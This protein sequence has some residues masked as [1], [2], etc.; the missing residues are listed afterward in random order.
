MDVQMPEMD[1]EEAT[2]QICSRWPKDER[3]RII[4]MT[5]HA[6]KGDRERYMEAGMDDY[7]TKPIRV[8]QLAK[9]LLRSTGSSSARRIGKGSD[10][11]A[12]GV[13]DVEVLGDETPELIALYVQDAGDLIE[14]IR[15]AIQDGDAQALERA[16][17]TLKSNSAT[18]GAMALADVCLRLEQ[19]GEAGTIEGAEDLLAQLERLYGRVRVALDDWPVV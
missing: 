16:A 15:Q 18:F 19:M 7:I 14:A 6:M 13:I 3:P 8:E 17:H 10:P 4:G 2:C 11:A 9:A 12:E 5:A 1:G